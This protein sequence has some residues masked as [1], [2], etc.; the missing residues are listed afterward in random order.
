M[1]TLYTSATSHFTSRARLR[2]SYIG[3]TMAA[4]SAQ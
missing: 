3:A 2:G 1:T 4:R